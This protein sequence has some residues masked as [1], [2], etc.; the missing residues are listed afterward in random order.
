MILIMEEENSSYEEEDEEPVLWFR[1]RFR[2]ISLYHSIVVKVIV[3]LMKIVSAHWYAFSARR[4]NSWTYL[5]VSVA[6]QMVVGQI[7]VPIH[8]M[9]CRRE[10]QVKVEVEE[11]ERHHNRHHQ[12]FLL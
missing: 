12:L 11:A 5:D 9:I 10:V 8:K 6:L 2:R 1:Y 4:M 3:I 7:I